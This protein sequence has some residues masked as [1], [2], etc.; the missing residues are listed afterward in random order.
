MPLSCVK[1]PGINKVMSKEVQNE[2]I[3]W[4]RYEKCIIMVREK[5]WMWVVR[6]KSNKGRMSWYEV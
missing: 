6:E 3:M 4:K 1:G 2:G 5:R